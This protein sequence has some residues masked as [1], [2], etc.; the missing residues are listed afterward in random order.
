MSKN[1]LG[2]RFQNDIGMSEARCKDLTLRIHHVFKPHPVN[3]EADPGLMCCVKEGMLYTL[4]DGSGKLRIYWAETGV[5]HKTI[6]PPAGAIPV[7]ERRKIA[8]VHERLWVADWEHN[9]IHVLD[10]ETCHL[11]N[12]FS[13]GPR[14]RIPTIIRTGDLVAIPD[15]QRCVVE[16][17]NQNGVL[18]ITFVCSPITPSGLAMTDNNCLVISDNHRKIFRILNIKQ[19][20]AL[21]VL[22]SIH[23]RVGKDS[24]V[25]RAAARSTLFDKN[26]LRLPM[27]LA[28]VLFKF[29]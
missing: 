1:V 20:I 25:A 5:L 16:F 6:R 13:L 8:F 24:V 19:P 2:F 7:S 11:I 3:E 27:R 9:T 28:G 10:K 22:S 14:S 29:K 4:Y 18:I 15:S 17:F 23:A 12:K 21:A 26:V